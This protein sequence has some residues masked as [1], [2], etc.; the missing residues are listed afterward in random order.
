MIQLRMVGDGY[1]R[2]LQRGS[3]A[4]SWSVGARPL[5]ASGRDRDECSTRRVEHHTEDI[6]SLGHL[7][8]FSGGP[9]RTKPMMALAK[10][11]PP[12]DHDLS[13]AHQVC[14]MQVIRPYSLLE[15][16]SSTVAAKQSWRS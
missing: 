9:S 12:Y 11:L 16:T 10:A 4:V 6:T 2:Q 5:M 3:E 13:Q 8:W 1:R 14:M 7:A 15:F